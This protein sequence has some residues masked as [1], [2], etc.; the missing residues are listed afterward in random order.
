MLYAGEI[1]LSADIKGGIQ[2][3]WL[4][5]GACLLFILKLP[6]FNVQFCNKKLKSQFAAERENIQPTLVTSGNLWGERNPFPP[7]LIKTHFLLSRNSTFSSGLS[8][9]FFKHRELY[10]HKNKFRCRRVLLEKADSK[11]P[12]LIHQLILCMKRLISFVIMRTFIIW[13][14]LRINACLFPFY[15]EDNLR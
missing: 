9:W 8:S 4:N 12:N 11:L 13:K 6:T 14:N 2:I 7:N 15:I 10:L 5:N 1:Q 3:S